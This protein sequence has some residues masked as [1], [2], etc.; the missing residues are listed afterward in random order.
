MADQESLT[1]LIDYDAVFTST[2]IYVGKAA[3]G[4]ASSAAVWQIIKL[5]LDINGNII[6]K[7]WAGGNDGFSH[8]WDNRASL[9]YS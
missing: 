8:I 9:S 5:T 4:S 6:S 7:K 3:R 2:P 1:V